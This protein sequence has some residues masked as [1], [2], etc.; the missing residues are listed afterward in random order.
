MSLAEGATTSALVFTL[1][2]SKYPMIYSLRKEFENGSD[3]VGEDV[4]FVGTWICVRKG[5]DQSFEAN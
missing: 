4:T 2:D 1:L 3:G 5:A